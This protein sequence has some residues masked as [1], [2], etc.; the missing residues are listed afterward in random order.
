MNNIFRNLRSVKS[1][2][3]S[4]APKALGFEPLESRV[5]LSVSPVT[6]SLAFGGRPS[7]GNLTNSR[8]VGKLATLTSPEL[9]PSAIRLTNANTIDIGQNS[10]RPLVGEFHGDLPANARSLNTGVAPVAAGVGF[11]IEATSDGGVPDFSARDQGRLIGNESFYHTDHLPVVSPIV[12]P[13]STLLDS[14]T[15]SEITS[16]PTMTT[17]LHSKSNSVVDGSGFLDRSGT[18]GESI[19][20]THGGSLGPE[21]GISGTTTPWSDVSLPKAALSSG[22]TVDLGDQTPANGSTDGVGDTANGSHSPPE[23]VGPVQDDGSTSP[24][25]SSVDGRSVTTIDVSVNHRQRKSN[26]KVVESASSEIA[27]ADPSTDGVR[28]QRLAVARHQRFSLANDRGLG[29]RGQAVGAKGSLEFENSQR[30]TFK[31]S[32]WQGKL[33]RNRAT[34][35]PGAAIAG[36]TQTV[37]NSAQQAHDGKVSLG[38][39][40]L[41]QS[42]DAQGLNVAEAEMSWG[43]ESFIASSFTGAL[44][45]WQTSSKRSMR[46]KR[47]LP[48]PRTPEK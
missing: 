26:P 21:S 47:T 44:I 48:R 11:Q 19:I 43:F 35:E 24:G 29:R 4:C 6:M 42:S 15:D 13:R 32:Q 22:T 40:A 20:T 18:F 14:G 17:P 3:R 46:M 9:E 36:Q 41:Q 7:S 33:D 16:T 28:Q 25:G 1:R 30:R 2:T 10:L 8:L 37:R 34:A 31:A 27:T 39:F 12:S 5:L 23:F 45:A 38:L